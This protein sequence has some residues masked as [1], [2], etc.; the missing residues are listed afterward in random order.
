M[1][2]LVDS[3]Q[4]RTKVSA[5]SDATERRTD[6][7]G[8]A[9]RLQTTPSTSEAAPCAKMQ[10]DSV[11]LNSICLSHQQL[12]NVHERGA[13]LVEACQARSDRF[14]AAFLAL[15]VSGLVPRSGLGGIVM[16]AQCRREAAARCSLFCFSFALARAPMGKG[17]HR[18]FPASRLAHTVR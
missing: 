18:P 12:R 8:P 10:H 15:A 1:A 17:R 11:K 13:S 14:G 5:P 3:R 4:D 7:I 2:I 16:R 9:R 6:W